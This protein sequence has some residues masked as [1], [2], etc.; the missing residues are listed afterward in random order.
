MARNYYNKKENVVKNSTVLKMKNKQ[1]KIKEARQQGNYDYAQQV[2]DDFDYIFQT[3]EIDLSQATQVISPFKAKTYTSRKESPNLTNLLKNLYVSDFFT[4]FSDTGT[5]A[6]S[7]IDKA[8]DFNEKII[9][10]E[11]GVSTFASYTN[12]V[13]SYD[14]LQRL[15][16]DGGHL[17]L[18]DTET[19][20]GK[21][22]SNIWN[23]LGITEFAMQKI[24]LQTGKYV[25]TNIALGV[26]DNQ[27]NKDMVEKILNA[28][29]DS[30]YDDKKK[31]ELKVD[32][33]IIMQNEELRVT[34]YRLA[35]YGGA[36]SQFKYDKDLGYMTAESLEDANLEDYLDPAKIKAGWQKNV[37]AF[38]SAKKTQYGMNAAQLAMVDSIA[39]MYQSTKQGTGIVGGQNI[40]PFDFKVVNTELNRIVKSLQ[41][42][43]DG[44]TS[45]INKTQAQAGINYIKSKFDGYTNISI[46]SEYIYDTLPMINFI[47]DTFGVDAL[48]N[49]NQEAIMAASNGTAKQEHVGAVWFPE[50][51]E[52]KQ[53]HKADF[54]VDVQ[55][56]LFMTPLKQ[57]DGTEHEGKTFMEYFMESFQHG[58]VKGLKNVNLK[59]QT[60]KA[61]GEQQ[62]F[63]LKKGTKDRT[64]A[65]KAALDHVIDKKT[66]EIFTSS[67]YEVVNGKMKFTGN[68]NMG[69]HMSK[70]HFYYVDSIKKI[71]TKDL[72]KQV[73]ELLPELSS[74]SIFQVRMHMAVGKDNKGQGLEDREY[75]LH[76]DNEYELSGWFSSHTSMPAIKDDKGNWKLN[77]DDALDILEQVSLEDGKINRDPGFYL[78]DPNQLVEDALN[79]K[80]KKKI[81]ENALREITDV[82]KQYSKINKQMKMRQILND[83]GIK[84]VTRDEINDILHGRTIS[85][86]SNM[87]K[88]KADELIKNVIHTLG[89]NPKDEA[90]VSFKLYGSTVNKTIGSWDFISMQ[91]GFYGKVLK[92]L[93]TFSEN[94]KLSTE[95]KKIVFNRA[96]EDLKAQVAEILYDTPEEMQRMVYNVKSFEGSLQE[97]KNVYDV[98]L[99]EDYIK[100]QPKKI[101]TKT[102]INALDEDGILSVRLDN[103]NSAPYDLVKQLVSAKYGTRN[104]RTNP[105]YYQRSALYKFV[106]HLRTLDEFDGNEFIEK[107]WAHM[108]A[109]T[110]NFNIATASEYVIKAMNLN[111][112]IDPSRGVLK[113]LNVG[114]MDMDEGFID[115]L[116]LL[117]KGFD[118]IG[119]PEVYLQTLEYHGYSPEQ[120]AKVRKLLN[121]NTFDSIK[122]VP[123][124]FDIGKG[125]GTSTEKI[126]QYVKDNL[127]QHYMPNKE[128][129]L[130]TFK[131]MTEEEK[132]HREKLYDLLEA[133]VTERL[134]DVTNALSQVDGGNLYFDKNG[135]IIFEYG[136]D[137]MTVDALPKVKMNG[138]ELYGQ[139]GNSPVELRLK[140]GI[141]SKTGAVELTTNLQ[142]SF[143]KGKAVTNRILKELEEGTFTIDS[144]AK[145]TSHLSKDFRQDSR[146]EF[147]SGNLYTNLLVDTGDL[148][149]ILP[150]LFNERIN[151]KQLDLSNILNSINIPDDVK[152]FIAEQ[153][154]NYDK[155]IESGELDPV[156]N[157]YLSSYRVQILQDYANAMGNQDLIRIAK[158]LNIGSKGKGKQ[159][160]GLL[161]GAGMRFEVGAVDSFNNLGRP[162]VDSSGN[163]RWIAAEKIDNDKVAKKIGGT[164]FKGAMLE[165]PVSIRANNFVSEGAG[166][167]ITSWTSRTA[168]VGEYGLKAILDNNFDKVMQANSVKHLAQ[169]QKENVYNMLYT[170]LNTFEQMK[171]FNARAFDEITKGTMPSQSIKLSSAVDLVN[172][173]R[174][175][176]DVGKYERMM[177]LIGNVS[178]DKDGVISYKS[179]KGI[180]VKRGESLVP[181]ALFGGGTENWSSNMSR[182]IFNFQ[183]S[184]KQGIKLTD[185]QV[186]EILNKNKSAFEGIDLADK[187]QVL[188]AIYSAVGQD[189]FEMNYVVEDINRT[190]LPK[191]LINDTEKSMNHLLYAKTGTLD[192]RVEKV[193]SMYSDET[194]DLLYHTVLTEQALDAYFNNVGQRRVVAKQAGFK[195]WGDFVKAWKDE[196]YSMSDMIFGKGGLFEGFTD[197]GSDALFKHENKGTQFLGSINEAILLLG[198]Y[199]DPKN[200][201]ENELTR[202]AGLKEFVKLYNENEEFQ[203]IRNNKAS[204]SKA[205]GLTVIDGRLRL[206]DGRRFNKDIENSDFIDYNKLEALIRHVD[207]TLE[208]KNASL[209]DRLIHTMRIEDDETRGIKRYINVGKNYKAGKDEKVEELIGR[210]I[211]S[212]NE[213]GE[214]EMFGTAAAIDHKLVVDSEVQ[215][216]MPQEYYDTKLD[217][218]KKK[219]QRINHEHQLEKLKNKEA[220]EGLTKKEARRAR[221]LERKI[222]NLDTQLEDMDEWLTNMDKT[223]HSFRI[224]DQEEKIIKNYFFDSNRE[225]AIQLQMDEGGL[226][227]DFYQVNEA[228]R[229]FDKEKYLKK[230]AFGDLVDRLHAQKYYNEFIDS[231]ELTSEMVE[232][233]RYKHLKKYYDEIIGNGL[234]DKLGVETA[235]QIYDIDMAALADKF[236]NVTGTNMKELTENGDFVIMSPKQY[237]DTFGD[238]KMPNYDAVSKKNVLLEFDLKDGKGKQYV[239]VPGMGSLT[240]KNEIKQTWH[241]HA[242]LF[243]AIYQDDFQ[244]AHGEPT[245]TERV[246]ERLN[247]ILGELRKSTKEVYEKGSALHKMM[248]QEVHAATDRVKILSMMPSDKNPLFNQAMVD[249]KSLA[250]WYK[251]G[252][253]YDYA[254]DSFESFE[255]R[256]YFDE[257]YLKKLN[258]SKDEM[259]EHLRTHGT[260]MLDD[261]Y[262]NIRERSVTP[263][264]HYLAM[265]PNKENFLANNATMMAPW[266][267]KALKADSDGDSVS[268][269]LIKGRHNEDYV[270]YGIARQ[271]AVELIDKTTP[272]LDNEKREEAIMQQTI[273]NMNEMQSR[274]IAKKKLKTLPK[275]NVDDYRNFRAKDIAMATLA[276]TDNKTK[277]FKEVIDQMQGDD[278]QTKKAML[279]KE[280]D[281]F[282]QAEYTGGKSILSMVRVQAL[283]EN[284][285][286]RFID[287]N[288][289]ELNKAISLIQESDKLGYFKHLDKDSKNYIESIITGSTDIWD[290]KNE[291]ESMDKI[292]YAMEKLKG[293]KKSSVG[294][295][296]FA[297]IQDAVFDRVRINRYHEE[298]MQKLGITATGNV[299]ATLY[300]VSQAIKSKYGDVAS[301]LYDELNRFVTS[302]I[303]YWMEETPISNKKF[304]IKAGDTRMFE[305]AQVFKDIEKSYMGKGNGPSDEIISNF[306]NYM[307][308]YMDHG[309]IAGTYDALQDKL[310]I[311]TV[312]R[313]ATKEEKVDSMIDTFTGMVVEALN[314][315]SD[316]YP[317]VIY[318]RNL[319]R[320]NARHGA[321]FHYSGRAP[322][323]SNVAEAAF[324]IHGQYKEGADI[325]KTIL[326]QSTEQNTTRIMN[327]FKTQINENKIAELGENIGNKLSKT[328]VHSGGLKSGLAMG[329]VGL[330]AGLIA[331][332]YASGNPLNDPDPAVFDQ[333]GYDGVKAA[334][335]MMFSSGQGFAP[336]NTGGYIINIKGDTRKGNRQ[337]KKALKQATRNSVGSAGVQMNIKTS[338]SGG[339]YSDRDIENI[340][341]NY[342]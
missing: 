300:G 143:S 129:W 178:I 69:S 259:I 322:I 217:Y 288:T 289:E 106:E 205:V 102:G 53:A 148:D 283:S 245:E 318:N 262:P 244:A 291:L 229:G 31:K 201:V 260:M 270:Q 185:E 254:F 265:G 86:M 333:K 9:M 77:S 340:L 122:N 42:V 59:A 239:A 104:L 191:I 29:G 149:S 32:P 94:H 25:K 243:S 304:K 34:A 138:A 180:A 167:L 36:G 287:K 95:Q 44:G 66:G 177:D 252:V 324:W 15:K 184:N 236:N 145:I 1:R 83:A 43:V 87:S 22:L 14:T 203:F 51:F 82:D 274:G 56:H 169:D 198:K 310:G 231:T 317:N 8:I 308:T 278:K 226:R 110:E 113:N 39:E 293:N 18:F 108:S 151:N 4:L 5:H 179:S 313:L 60:I 99:P 131:G 334:P 256:G 142:D 98:K 73:G 189:D 331:S 96:V 282:L 35:L 78:N 187:K 316:M 155:E 342:F 152:K 135:R 230:T 325:P 311:P 202:V 28:L 120:L 46:D 330:A 277:W 24:D 235:Q 280:G 267:M 297:K 175:E 249:G 337:L 181:Y 327:E 246:R 74:Q 299:N 109:D 137:T 63:Y 258:M 286:W 173:V 219:G 295:D 269:V 306:K 136:K 134:V 195:S 223:G 12:V 20:G 101:L 176:K 341:N 248:R 90:D 147:R 338:N 326:T 196:M 276:A 234:A 114:T 292:L 323:N 70:G 123:I 209:E 23:P 127:L 21:N 332:G 192:K 139:I 85:R 158:N 206:E 62:L 307:K 305:F 250:D 115:A 64:F 171:V 124:P 188:R 48:Y 68:M 241:K 163:V 157:Q 153:V 238:P 71:D 156:L 165:D 61:G 26:E 255:K 309:W 6:N 144:V 7:A 160:H 208:Q 107:S 193:F 126:T 336:N 41:D 275:F 174:K 141:N 116:N 251:E 303:A 314:P 215:S 272:M 103:K 150:K 159:E 55:R 232:K 183:I 273:D 194:K 220:K 125:K 263:V 207:S 271:R 227:K 54:D 121:I 225:A 216:S 186:S 237:V 182:G 33:N 200:K 253:Y 118:Y 100:V 166:E 58:N 296:M 204:D 76:F 302:D 146:Y 218:L 240:E 128:K 222:T 294:E 290:H 105:E 37:D 224:G 261:R 11:Q 19:I 335:E 75:V 268:R 164:F 88:E 30:L 133:Q 81:T 57:L 161:M 154:G 27:A 315:N 97:L 320:R 339:M 111:K 132:W 190:M 170:Y 17:Y 328:V 298:G 213:R 211:F 312:S 117:S 233:G 45:T 130:K 79:V 91:E 221:D 329:V 168:Y 72:P 84:N 212:K 301:P 214:M 80:N 257:D 319:G 199:S 140:Y 321:A 38:H 247:T 285:D 119:D 49:F 228:F 197:I 47:K 10:N 172:V 67:N 266:T 279:L 3:P 65:G 264:R 242:G 92:D 13:K 162:V 281:D 284:P 50:L 2:F 93:E 16:R 52:S 89:F 112:D 40:V 210:K